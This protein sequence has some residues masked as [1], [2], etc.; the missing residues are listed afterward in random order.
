MKRN[1][2][3]LFCCLWLVICLLPAWACGTGEAGCPLL[4]EWAFNYEPEKTAL[5]ILEDG[6]AEYGGRAFTWED[7]GTF[8]LLTDGETGEEV[9]LRYTADEEKVLL[10]LPKVYVRADGVPG[11]GLTGAWIGRE[12]TGSTFIFLDDHRFLEDG[13]FTGTFQ[14]EAD[15][16][17]PSAGTFL[18]VYPQYFDDTLCFFRLEGNDILTVEYPWPLVEP[19]A[20]PSL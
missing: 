11:E 5:R 18:L 7:D 1:F 3:R 12:T 15:E 16:T 6:T 17:D 13:T 14:V 20:A 4:G 8:L 9:S 10:Y 19:Q 2:P